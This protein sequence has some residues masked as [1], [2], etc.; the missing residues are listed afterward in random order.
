MAKLKHSPIFT[1][2]QYTLYIHTLHTAHMYN[3]QCTEAAHPTQSANSIAFGTVAD[4]RMILT[5]S[6][7]RIS[8]SSHTTPL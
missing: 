2:I 8:T 6:G 3:S 1:T 7:S 4:K 5:W